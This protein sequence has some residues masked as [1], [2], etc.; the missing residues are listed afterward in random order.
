MDHPENH[1][2][3]GFQQRLNVTASTAGHQGY[4]PTMPHQQNTFGILGQNESDNNSAETVA[5][6]VAALTYQS[7]MTASSMANASQCAEQQ[8]AHLASQQNMMH[9]NM[10]QIIAQVNAL[11]FNQSNAGHGRIAGNN[12][13]GNGGPGNGHEQRPHRS[14]NIASNRGQFGTGGSFTPAT[15]FFAPNPPPGGV[16]PYEGPLQRQR[17]TGFG[18]PRPP[19]SIPHGAQTQYHPFAAPFLNMRKSLLTEMCAIQAVLMWKMA[20]PA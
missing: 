3:G 4:A 5:T 14:Q 8:F 1:D 6:Q 17:P 2:P 19:V 10:H 7:Q 15:E 11:S 12:F 18:A 16:R 20:T 13:K 9:K